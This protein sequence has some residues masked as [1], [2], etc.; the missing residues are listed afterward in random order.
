M[1]TIGQEV[2]A[3]RMPVALSQSCVACIMLAYKHLK[4]MAPVLRHEKM[5]KD[6]VDTR[7]AAAY[8]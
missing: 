4:N 8:S 1:L 7:V 5:A 3:M 6:S 2:T